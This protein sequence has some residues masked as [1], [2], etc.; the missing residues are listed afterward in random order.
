MC[1]S[2]ERGGRRCAAH[3]RPGY[4]AA[5]TALNA[6]PHAEVDV[7]AL[8]AHA[9]TP[10]GG[11]ELAN[12][13]ERRE[14][15]SRVS[16]A[17][18]AADEV[19]H[20]TRLAVLREAQEQARVQAQVDADVAAA[21]ARANTDASG[22]AEVEPAPLWSGI[23]PDWVA[24]LQPHQQRDL[25]EDGTFTLRD[26][27]GDPVEVTPGVIDDE[28]DW[29]FKRGQCLSLAV[30][31]AEKTGGK[32]YCQ[33]VDFGDT[34]ENDQPFYGLRH[35]YVQLPDGT[36]LDI[37]GEHGAP[38]DLDEDDEYDDA[39]KPVE[40]LT[41]DDPRA[42]LAHFEGHLEEQD[43]VG[44]EP[45]ASTVL[46]HH[47]LGT[48]V[49]ERNYDALTPDD[50]KALLDR[51]LV[52]RYTAGDC[53]VLAHH[54]AARNGWGV[55]VVGE[56][57]YSEFDEDH[58]DDS[59]VGVEGLAHAY[60]VRPDG[61]LVDVRGVHSPASADALAAQWSH[62]RYDYPDAAAADRFWNHEQWFGSN[63]WDDRYAEEDEVEL[64][65]HTAALVTRAYARDRI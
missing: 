41:F 32:V 1:Q 48:Y 43:V 62:T 45:F 55:C 3:T 19:E 34:D 36:L 12:E 11:I 15:A 30:A 13:I 8:V 21:T 29:V 4:L 65:Q 53:G 25:A 60:A 46:A 5:L 54:L 38:A 57:D 52:H 61:A 7:A 64:V 18:S 50:A 9:S 28:A 17:G 20:Q 10:S 59:Y 42:A 47:R 35:A 44:A 37:Q 22:L 2:K 58:P 56:L 49:G 39:G 14:E 23:D 40:P 63:E 26:A 51:P 31:L 16:P 6:A 24:R 27:S 33:R